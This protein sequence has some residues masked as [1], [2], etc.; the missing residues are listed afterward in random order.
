MATAV[1]FRRGTTSE[2]SSFTGLEGEITVDTDKDTVVVHD[3]STAGG[4]PL[5]KASEVSS[6]ATQITTADEGTD[7]ECFPV[8]TTD[9]VG[10]LAPKTD[11]AFKYNA[12]NGTVTG[13]IFETTRIN[14]TGSSGNTYIDFGGTSPYILT[15][16]MAG[17]GVLGLTTSGVSVTGEVNADSLDIDGEVK[18][19]SLDIDGN[20]DISGDLTLSAGGD[21][22]LTFANAGENSIKIPDNQAS[23]L[24]IEEANTAYMTFVTTDSGEKVTFGKD[25]DVTG[26]VTADAITSHQTTVINSTNQ[27]ASNFYGQRM[28]HTG[29]AVTYAFAETGSISGTDIGKSV[30]IANAGTDSI[31][32]NFTNSKFY[33]MIS[34]VNA[35]VGGSGVSSITIAKGG[36]AEVVI[37]ATDK[38]IVFGAGVS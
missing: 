18:G 5:A 31:T 15:L 16:G 38:A 9:A 35:D 24:I 10:N 6:V 37:T 14:G 33:K 20:A 28:I 3:G 7:A 32:C 34:G 4:I 13:N 1:Q 25:I 27:T 8:F 23:A 21:G 17:A 26:T 19:N 12:S 30:I 36:I 2:H 22:A 11:T 29:A